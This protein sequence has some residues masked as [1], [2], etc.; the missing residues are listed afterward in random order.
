MLK[1]KQHNIPD[2]EFQSA[3]KKPIPIR[4]IQINESF[5]VE[6]LEGIMRGKRGD[7]LMI[8]V[9]GEMYPCDKGIFE[10]TYDLTDGT[11]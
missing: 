4:C 9:N 10:K 1:F 5:E 3:I 8:G 11:E 6:T 7:W 2:L